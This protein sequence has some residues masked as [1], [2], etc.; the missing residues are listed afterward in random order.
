M[1]T[2]SRLLHGWRALNNQQSTAFHIHES[3]GCGARSTVCV[4]AAQSASKGKGRPKPDESEDP[5]QC[6]KKIMLHS[7]SLACNSV[8]TNSCSKQS[9]QRISHACTGIYKNT[10]NLPET[11]FGMRANAKQREP[12]I[13][14]L[15]QDQAIYQSLLESNTGEP[16]TLHDG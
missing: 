9:H 11:S 5:L 7:T 1:R 2:G 12:Q 4:R 14:Q 15:W 10:V 6:P 3:R 13:Q 16:F 8:S